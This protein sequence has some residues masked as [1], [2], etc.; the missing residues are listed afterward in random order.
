MAPVVPHR[1]SYAL[2]RLGVAT[3]VVATI[4]SGL[5]IPF[6]S[7]LVGLSFAYIVWGTTNG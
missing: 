6:G 2:G 1:V 4:L 7:L 5:L 3:A